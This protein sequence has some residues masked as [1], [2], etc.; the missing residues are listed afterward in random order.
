MHV[1]RGRSRNREMM[2]RGGAVNRMVVDHRP[3][4]L[5]IL[6]V[7]QEEKEE[8]MPHFVVRIWQDLSLQYYST[9]LL[10]SNKNC[11][12]KYHFITSYMF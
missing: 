11:S 7:T 2:A 4:A 6:G 10:L 5:A 8:L 12:N 3:R 9:M 1:G